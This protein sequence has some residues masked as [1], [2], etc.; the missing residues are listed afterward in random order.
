M[1]NAKGGFLSF[2]T[3]VHELPFATAH[4]DLSRTGATVNYNK[5]AT[6]CV[7]RIKSG[8][9]TVSEIARFDSLCPD[10]WR[11]S[12]AYFLE[13][14]LRNCAFN[15]EDETRGNPSLP[16]VRG[17]SQRDEVIRATVSLRGQRRATRWEKATDFHCKC[18]PRCG[19]LSPLLAMTASRV[20]F[21]PE[22]KRQQ[23]G[24]VQTLARLK[25]PLTIRRPADS[26]I[27]ASVQKVTSEFP[28]KEK[29]PRQTPGLERMIQ[30]D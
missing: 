17:K 13:P 23:A 30:Q 29:K 20:N 11:T 15:Q 18:K 3:T 10:F 14:A 19:V 22:G 9:S 6:N 2:L 27:G 12:G 16:Q 25:A 1:N 4:H 8:H 21:D 7:A 24:A 28:G 26:G 5:T